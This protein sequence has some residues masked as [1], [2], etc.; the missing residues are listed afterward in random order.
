MTCCH[1]RVPHMAHWLVPCALHWALPEHRACRVTFHFPPATCCP[2]S[3]QNFTM[4][5]K[6]ET[7]TLLPGDMLITS[8]T[9]DT[10][11]RTNY[12]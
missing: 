3:A 12:T 1:S 11:S 9:F 10:T 8:C 5:P 6:G 2:P 7:R 4:V